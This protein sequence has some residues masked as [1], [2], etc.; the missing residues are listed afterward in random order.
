[1]A[2]GRRAFTKGLNLDKIGIELDEKGRIPV[3]KDLKTKISNIY[4]VGDVV[5]GPMLAH[6]GSEEG[7]AAVDII[8]GGT[9]HI[10]HNV[11]PNV[12][13]TTP[14]VAYVGQTEEELKKKGIEYNKGK[15]PF[16]ANSRAKCTDEPEG[17]VKVLSEKK[18]DKLL[19]IHIIGLS[20]GE[21]ISECVLSMEYGASSEDVGRTVHA[22]PT[23]SEA[24][25]EA[26]LAAFDKPLN[27]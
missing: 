18:T 1:V 5:E 3:G 26:C 8:C 27:F 4:A 9:G 16:L 24:V 7:V 25:K 14:E 20:A 11:I 23:L 6:K 19:G 2:V 17:F 10:N 22:H 15:F 21:L 12:L 13:Y